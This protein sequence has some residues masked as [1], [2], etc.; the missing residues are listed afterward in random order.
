MNIAMLGTGFVNWSGGI[1][2]L[3][4]YM[5]P[6][7]SINK[8]N[9]FLFL[10]KDNCKNI[11][12][13][14][15]KNLVK[16]SVG[17]GIPDKD[18]LPLELA[19]KSFS[20][21]MDLKIV[22]F[23]KG[24]RNDLIKKL[25]MNKIELIFPTLE[26][27]GRKF[28][29]PWVPYVFDFQHK[30][31]PEFFTA[32]ECKERDIYFEKVL[33]EARAVIVEANDV[34]KDIEKYY[35]NA[36]AKVFV[37]PYTAIPQKQWFY[38]DDINLMKYNLPS[39]YFMISNQ[40]WIHKSHITAFEALSILHKKGY[41]DYHIV[42][43]GNTYDYRFPRYFSEIKTRLKELGIDNY[44]HFLGFIPKLD[45]IKIMTNSVAVLQPTLFEGNPGGGC[46]YN[47][48]A[49][50]VSILLSDIDVNKE[51]HHDGVEFFQVKSSIDMEKGMER[52]INLHKTRPIRTRKELEDAGTQ[53][54]LQLKEQIKQV[55]QYVMSQHFM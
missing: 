37:M 3:K 52:L 47:A 16:L 18:E 20:E 45:Q 1:D 4:A 30:Y 5:E 31:Y 21:C 34:K 26:V 51:L 7:K 27:L 50:G 48:I 35:P 40:M 41:S 39:K 42:C 29:I 43:T 28:P 17:R 14:R 8:V 22:V 13:R 24:N 10:P 12:F 44:V 32:L 33:N 53:Q 9:V 46:A 2:F 54:L 55:I 6:L 49:M 38:L 15:L 19:L 25:H 11:F 23:E 36:L